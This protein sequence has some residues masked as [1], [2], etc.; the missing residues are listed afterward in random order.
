MDA[1]DT[2][3][4]DDA[5]IMLELPCHHEAGA[6]QRVLRVTHAT[7]RSHG[8]TLNYKP[9]KTTAMLAL[10]AQAGNNSSSAP[11]DAGPSLTKQLGPKPR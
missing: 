5:A 1:S 8:F 6:A 7:M 11:T 4:A 10:T 2:S 9:G 3:F